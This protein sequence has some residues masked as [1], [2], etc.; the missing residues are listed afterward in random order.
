MYHFC[1]RLM[2]ISIRE[3]KISR[4]I[5]I[6]FQIFSDDTSNNSMSTNYYV[7]CTQLYT[8]VTNY[9]YR[10]AILYDIMSSLKSLVYMFGHIY[11][12]CSCKCPFIKDIRCWCTQLGDKNGLMVTDVSIML[13][14]LSSTYFTSNIRPQ[15]RLDVMESLLQGVQN[16]VDHM[17]K[18]F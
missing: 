11:T 18:L 7:Y 4:G 3:R 10:L 6:F 8:M 9:R 2:C 16:Q 17:Q 13:L 15:H 12:Q 1:L 14:F 5:S